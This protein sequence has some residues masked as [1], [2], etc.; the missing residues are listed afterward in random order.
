MPKFL[1]DFLD[2]WGWGALESYV[3]FLFE[4]EMWDEL[5]AVCLGACFWSKIPKIHGLED[6]SS[7]SSVDDE[8]RA[9][10][11]S[12]NKGATSTRPRCFMQVSTGNGLENF[13]VTREYFTLEHNKPVCLAMIHGTAT[14][15]SKVKELWDNNVKQNV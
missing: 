6:S 7:A 1:L 13:P 5:L 2:G 12:P 8:K 10:V 15:L 3:E 4:N 14:R 11:R 9:I